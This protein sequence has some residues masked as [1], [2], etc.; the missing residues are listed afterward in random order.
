M[1]K[2]SLADTESNRN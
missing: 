1:N 2:R